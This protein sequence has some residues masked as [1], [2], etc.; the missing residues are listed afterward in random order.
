MEKEVW[1]DIP[2]YEGYYQIS[3]EGRVRSIDRTVKD[4]NGL[5]KVYK[6]K[7]LKTSFKEG[8]KCVLLSKGNWKKTKLIDELLKTY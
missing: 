2:N 7:I 1:K 3:S 5:E 8:E 4:K 6:G